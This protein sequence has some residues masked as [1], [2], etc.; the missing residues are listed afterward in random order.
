M[1]VISNQRLVAFAKQNADSETP[2]QTW[3][4]I[5]TKSTPANFAE[6]R[7]MFNSVDHVDDLYVFN[8]GG[9]KYRVVCGI[10]FEQ[11]I[12]YVKHV[13]THSE[14]DRGRWKR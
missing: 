6:L 4:K 3:R 11:G 7:R 10:N 9:N 14:Y 1:R 8:V 5:L 2:L 12:C 13:L